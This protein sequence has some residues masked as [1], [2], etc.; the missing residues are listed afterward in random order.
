MNTEDLLLPP[1]PL[2]P[3]AGA[4]LAYIATEGEIKPWAM[5]GGALAGLLVNVAT[6]SIQLQSESAKTSG[7]GEFHSSLGKELLNAALGKKPDQSSTVQVTSG[8]V[9]YRLRGVG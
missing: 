4:F 5:L 6:R 8:P 7:A 1:S 9:T 2:Y 3:A